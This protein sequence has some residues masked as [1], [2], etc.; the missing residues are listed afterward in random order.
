MDKLK[1]KLA[2]LVI[3]LSVCFL[4]LI[5]YTVQRKHVSF[6]ENGV[7]TTLNSVQGVVYNIGNKVKNS[8]S[9]I[10]H[11]KD[12]KSENEKLKEDNKNLDKLKNENTMLADENARLRENLKFK[13]TRS[14]YEYIGADIVGRSGQNFLDGFT[15]NRGS[16]DGI[17]K[18]MIAVTS[19]GLV[20]Q[21]TSVGNNSATIQTLCNENIAVAG[22]VLSTKES[23]GIVK[24]YKG[25]ED[26]FLAEITGL[27]I[28]S[29]IKVGD[30][31]VT[32]GLGKIYPKGIEI[33]K[34]LDVKE[35][36][37]AVMK[38]AVVKPNVD[39]NKLEQVLIVVQ[40]EKRN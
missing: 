16:K 17:E 27:S 5:G 11:I 36:K 8:F 33:G 14:E 26:K 28:D 7:G 29:G 40:K 23:D 9:F 18:G 1:N 2:V 15:I 21:V 24:G 32:S 25:N 35:D 30:T 3:I 20:G 37:A 10:F 12:L 4:F 39:F 6:V 22:Y 31:I 34:V 19:V 13:D 38:S